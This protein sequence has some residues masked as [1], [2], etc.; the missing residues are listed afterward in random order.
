MKQHGS[1]TTRKIAEM[2]TFPGRKK[3]KRENEMKEREKKGKK[4]GEKVFG[5]EWDGI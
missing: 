4:E 5:I 3:G 2:L 1:G